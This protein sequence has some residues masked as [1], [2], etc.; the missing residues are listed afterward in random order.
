MFEGSWK[1]TALETNGKS[2]PAEALQGMRWTFKGSEVRFADPGE[3]PGGRSAITLDP[4]KTPRHIDLVGQEGP[5]KGKTAHGIYKLEKDRLVI[6]L[7]DAKTASKGRPQ[8]FK[9]EA[10]SGLGMITLER[11]KE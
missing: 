4:G 9:T 5:E 7:R 6:C 1:V 10:G 3:E 8:E 11:A 2:A